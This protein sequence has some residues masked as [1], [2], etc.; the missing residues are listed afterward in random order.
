MN[1]YVD[2]C[3]DFSSYVCGN[4]DQLY[5]VPP[6][7]FKFD[8]MSVTEKEIKNKL[9]TLLGKIFLKT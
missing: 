1:D 2:P 7:D 9:K 5:S 6:G 3:D 8:S 4:F